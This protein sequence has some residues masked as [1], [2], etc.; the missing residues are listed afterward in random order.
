MS[1]STDPKKRKTE[2][3]RHRQAVIETSKKLD[4]PAPAQPDG[5]VLV[6]EDD[7]VRAALRRDRNSGFIA[8]DEIE[9]DSEQVRHVDTTS[10]SFEE[11]VASVREHGVLQ[12][13]TVRWISDRGVF[14]IITG[15]RRYQAAKRVGLE[16]IP[17]VRKD[18]DDTEKS[19]HQLVENIQREN[20]NPIDEAKAFHRYMIASGAKQR[21][22]AKKIGK[23]ETYVSLLMSILE[24]LNRVEQAEIEKLSPAKVPGRTL[25][26]EALRTDDSQLRMAILRGQYS[27]SQARELVQKTKPRVIDG[28]AKQFS[29]RF[30]SLGSAKATVTVTFP[31]ARVTN[32][33]IT[34]ALLDAK[35]A[36]E[37]SI[38][39]ERV[40]KKAR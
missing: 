9:A 23:T 28:R 8:L 34:R 39:D 16:T 29:R 31:K 18:V 2:A 13:I 1:T 15:E 35:R 21:D 17:A 10:D 26:L 19:I 4:R 32:E 40:A 38:E 27:R 20:M 33:E 25:I 22:L 12:P 5:P 7:R 6:I 30:P 37:K 24:K 3:D 14:Q 11:L 36:L